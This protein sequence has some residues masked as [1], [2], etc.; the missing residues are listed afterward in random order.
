MRW[1]RTSR[2]VS[3]TLIE[4][5]TVIAI[6]CVMVALIT[7]ATL[8]AQE[9]GR[10]A[11]CRSNLSQIHRLILQYGATYGGYM[12]VF[13]HE[14]WVGELGL[15]GKDWGGL[16]DDLNPN[17]PV[18]WGNFSELKDWIKDEVQ[19]QEFN[20]E[21]LELLYLSRNPDVPK[22]KPVSR[23]YLLRTASP[24]I[25]CRSDGVLFRSDQGC[26]V[27]YVGL[28]KYG[29]WNR[30]TGGGGWF[31]EPTVDPTAP[32]GVTWSTPPKYVDGKCYGPFNGTGSHFEYH[33]MTEFEN[34]SGRIML[35]ETDP[36]TWQ[37][38]PGSCGCRWFTYT[39]PQDI[40]RRHYDGGN[41]LFMDGHVE[42]VREQQKMKISYWEPGYDSVSPEGGY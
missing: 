15:V 16:R 33:Q 7:T 20:P 4:L 3:F 2:R 25:V 5:L 24:V 10:L 29:W 18:V 41:V 32:G 31:Q 35:C 8:S 17:I 28:A 40:Q 23:N 37:Y 21:T 1:T 11:G 12:P 36:A 6:I 42:L 26:V 30:G 38:E 34:P 14:R 22:M 39:H 19:V 27:S 9:S 13:W